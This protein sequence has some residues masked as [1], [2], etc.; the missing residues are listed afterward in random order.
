MDTVEP[1]LKFDDYMKELESDLN[2]IISDPGVSGYSSIEEQDII[3]GISITVG[4]NPAVDTVLDVGCGIG[5]L[6]YYTERFTGSKPFKYIGL[7]N[8][9]QLLDIN[10]FRSGQDDSVSLINLD[11][12]EF[13]SKYYDY[14]ESALKNLAILGHDS[15]IDWVV[16]CNMLDDTKKGKDIASSIIFWSKVPTKGS[17]FTFKVDDTKKLME[18]LSILLNNDDINKK[19][20]FRSDFMTGWVSFYIYNQRD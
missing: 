18:C 17:V 14:S 7:D 9:E 16:M 10:K 3:Y 19:L 8:N 13:E 15:T 6:Y 11:I 2:E 5:E 4:I 12:S 20:I 1:V